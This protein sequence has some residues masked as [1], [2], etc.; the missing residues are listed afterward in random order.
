VAERI[1]IG[2]IVS[3][4]GIK[5]EVKV[6]PWTDDTDRF[7][8]LKEVLI[9]K[10]EVVR[11]VHIVSARTHKNVVILALREFNSVNEAQELAGWNV[12]IEHKDLLPLP[13]GR[14]YIFQLV[15]LK[16]RTLDGQELGVLSEVLQTGANDVYVVKG[17]GGKEVLI[18]AL[19]SVVKQIDLDAQQVL[20]DPLPGLLED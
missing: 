1:V 6:Y 15:G 5:G 12:E 18:P 3:A 2:K 14:Y 20:I 11:T 9:V 13:E 10:D 4:H 17:P 16:V 19:K 8:L 7:G